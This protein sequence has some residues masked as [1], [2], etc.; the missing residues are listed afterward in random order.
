M[1]ILVFSD[2][3]GNVQSMLRAISVFGPDMIFHLGDNIRDCCPIEANYPQIPV[4]KVVGNCDFGE[5]GNIRRVF[6]LEGKRFFLTHGHKYSVK[7]GRELLRAAAREHKA[8]IVLF[9]HTHRQYYDDDGSVVMINPGSIG[10][11]RKTFGV[12]NIKNGSFSYEE[13]EDI[14]YWN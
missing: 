11:G 6:D 1:K 13:R 5:K 9:G 14:D 3:H 8:G 7:M 4:E 10:F 2:S 12:I